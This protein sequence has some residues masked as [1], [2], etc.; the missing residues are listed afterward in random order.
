MKAVG[1]E[2]GALA[3]RSPSHSRSRRGAGAHGVRQ[4]V[5]AGLRTPEQAVR[6]FAVALGSGDLDA[7]VGCFARDGCFVTPDSTA[8]RGREDIRAILA[9]MLAGCLWIGIEARGML[10]AGDVALGSERWTIGSNGAG[11]APFER[12]SNSTVVARRIEGTWKLAI[13]A[14]WAEGRSVV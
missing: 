10:T 7:A 2:E 3:R 12:T 14:P 5:Q 6:A 4:A 13:V 9:Q 8:I 11:R 1:V